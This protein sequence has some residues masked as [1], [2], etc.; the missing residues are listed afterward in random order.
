M[1]KKSMGSDFSMC[2]QPAFIVGTYNEDGTPDF[3]PIT[4]V[5]VTCGKNG[6]YMIV[7]SM[8]GDKNTK[9]N[10]LRSGQFTLNLAS[11]DM[12]PL[13]DYFGQTSG[14]D[15]IKNQM[16]YEYGNAQNVSAP[17]L[18]MSRWVYECQV[19]NRV[20][21][22]SSDTFFC[23]IENVQIDE[24]LEVENTWSIDLLKLDPVIYSGQYFSLDKRLG[25]IGDFYQP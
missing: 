19:M 4:W 11:R 24:A 20:N 18:D 9:R 7:I 2:V 17:I 13:V 23:A 5:S 6:E 1:K 21:T 3:A 22:G 12:L 15:G 16:A 14:K 10:V 25:K 8:Y